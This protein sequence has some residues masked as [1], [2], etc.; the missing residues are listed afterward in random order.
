[1]F[2]MDILNINP[3]YIY[4]N[5]YDI[6]FKD[7]IKNYLDYF[8][9]DSYA[10]EF[11]IN[12]LVKEIEKTNSITDKNKDLWNMFMFP[13]KK[14]NFHSFYKVIEKLKNIKTH[15]FAVHIANFLLYTIYRFIQVHKS[16]IK[17]QTEKEKQ[18]EKEKEQR[19][20]EIYN[21]NK[22]LIKKNKNLIND[23]KI[24]FN[25]NEKLKTSLKNI[26]EAYAFYKRE[27]GYVQGMSYLA[28]MLLLNMKEINAFIS[29]CNLLN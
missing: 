7:N 27:I 14:N 1:L 8:K 17:M 21:E 24:I 13:S 11:D 16:K 3:D 26:L 20:K 23:K 9:E 28:G 6:E 22:D 2:I 15:L 29:F 4:E 25:E 12:I 10:F 18:V 5:F 19:S